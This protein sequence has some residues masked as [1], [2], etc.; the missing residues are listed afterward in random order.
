[1]NKKVIRLRCPCGEMI[2][3]GSEDELVEKANA[4]LEEVHPEMAGAYTR[5]Q[6][7]FMAY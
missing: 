7:L 1:M 5:D 4:H 3:A 6:I 2:E